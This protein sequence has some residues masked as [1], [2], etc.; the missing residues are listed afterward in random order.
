M[1]FYDKYMKYKKKYL[2]LV[3]GSQIQHGGGYSI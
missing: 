3:G 2:E 1:S